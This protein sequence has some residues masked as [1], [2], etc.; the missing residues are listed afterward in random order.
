MKIGIVSP[1][2]PSSTTEEFNQFDHGL[3]VLQLLGF[4]CVLAPHA[5]HAQGYVSSGIQ[6]RLEDL[7]AMY[8]D[9]TIDFVLAS[10][11][12]KNVN[13][14]LDGLDYNLIQ[15]SKKP[16]IGFSDITILLNAIYVKTGLCQ[17]H[18]PMVTWGFHKRDSFTHR[19]FKQFLRTGTLRFPLSRF[20]KFLKNKKGV[21]DGILVGGNL[22]ALDKLLGTP[23]EP[24]WNGKILFWEENRENI[25]DLDCLLT[26]FKT[27]HVWDKIHGMI[28]GQLFEINEKYYNI[29]V[30][31][32]HMIR[33]HF[34]KY[35][36]PILT[37]EFFG[38]G[39]RNLVMPVGGTIKTEKDFII[40]QKPQ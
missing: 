33:G 2:S 3:R 32:W 23:Y 8:Q 27:A 21:L 10:N 28:I 30:D 38:H 25:A 24:D 29:W 15:T 11:G 40:I 4:E 19:S 14:L 18:G 37:T 9:P 31:K 36:F 35:K 13:Q 12:G 1:S 6:N 16:L 20:G 17:L 26:H 34:R 39:V 5:R 22:F 7:H